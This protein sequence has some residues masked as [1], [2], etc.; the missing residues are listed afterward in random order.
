MTELTE[1]RC[2]CGE[3][4]HYVNQEYRA[5]IESYCRELGPTVR[6]Q[7][8]KGVW[9]V[10]RHYMALHGLKAAKLPELAQ[11]YGFEQVS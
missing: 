9:L 4:L 10:P 3:P 5:V 8:R 1:Q 6:I 7:T 2:A 11:R